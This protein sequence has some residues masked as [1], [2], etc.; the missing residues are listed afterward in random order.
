METT[1]RANVVCPQCHRPPSN[2]YYAATVEWARSL[3]PD[4]PIENVACTR[5]DCGTV[6]VVAAHALQT[7][8]MDTSRRQVLDGVKRAA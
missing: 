8:V 2:R 1:W 3:E 6:Y 5:R 4:H 7:A